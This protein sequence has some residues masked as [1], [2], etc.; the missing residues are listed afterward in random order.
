M[1]EWGQSSDPFSPSQSN[2]W[3]APPMSS[4]PLSAELAADLAG[5][6]SGAGFGLGGVGLAGFGLLGIATPVFLFNIQ[7]QQA[8]N[9]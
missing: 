3:Y 5:K 9:V 6:G 8:G 1:E 2:R 7:S 4:R